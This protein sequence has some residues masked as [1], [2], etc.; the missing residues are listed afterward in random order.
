LT[1]VGLA[2]DSE[3]DYTVESDPDSI[4]S[5]TSNLIFSLLSD[6]SMK[7]NDKDKAGSDYLYELT[8]T[9]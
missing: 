9:L 1:R 6:I 4:H 7:I 3:W 2:S 5:I 8:A